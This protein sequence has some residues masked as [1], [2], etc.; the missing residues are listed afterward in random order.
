M[1]SSAAS[2]R[3]QVPP[4]LRGLRDVRL[5]L[6]AGGEICQ[7]LPEISRPDTGFADPVVEVFDCLIGRTAAQLRENPNCRLNLFVGP[8]VIEQPVC[9]RLSRLRRCLHRGR[10]CTGGNELFDRRCDLGWGFDMREV[11]Q[12]CEHLK[13]TAGARRSYSVAVFDGDDVIAVTPDD[14]GGYLG[15]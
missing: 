9:A 1:L 8:K 11:A 5:W 7:R 2:Q 14:Q 10:F 13:P 12:A 15:P 6:V 3:Q 4:P